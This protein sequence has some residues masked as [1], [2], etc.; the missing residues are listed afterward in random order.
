VTAVKRRRKRSTIIALCAAAVGFMAVGVLGVSGVRSLSD[1]TAGRRADGQLTTEAGRR[2]PFTSTA[3]VGVVDDDMRLTSI[4]VWILEPDGVGGSII[5]LAATADVSSGTID[6]LAPLDAVYETGGPDEFLASAERLTGLTFDVVEVVDAKRFAELISPLGDL[7]AVFPVAFTD[8]SSGEQWEAG[9]TTLSSPAAARALTATDPSIADWYFE[10]GRATVWEAVAD[11]VGAGVG[12]VAP[13]ASDRDVPV[14]EN[15]DQFADR[16]FGS[17]VEHRALGFTPIDA[18]R[19]DEQ[20]PA[21]Y[22][23]MFGPVDAVV[24][25]DRAEMAILFGAAA[26]GRLGAPFDAP[27]FRVVSPF[28]PADLEGTGLNSTDVLKRAIDGLYFAQANVVSVADL[29]ELE[30]PD[31]T[32]VLVADPEVTRAV[33]TLYKPIFGEIEVVPTDDPIEGIDVEVILG[34]TFLTQLRSE[35]PAGVAGSG[36]DE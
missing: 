30:V 5:G 34:Q 16:L 14:P 18:E 23:G 6:T 28:A 31:V 35:P 17:A 12:S 32:R 8:A 36:N 24:V 3:L 7:P 19:V 11:R 1:S 15:L 9:E 2:L 33:R 29:P 4:A 20:L 13:I 27:V 25:H 21:A 26:P 22:V 10:S